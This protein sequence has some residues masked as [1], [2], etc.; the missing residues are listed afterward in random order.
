MGGAVGLGL[1]ER[2]RDAAAREDWQQAFELFM[3]AETDGLLAPAELALLGEV[4][5]AA[6]HLDVAIEAW[7][8]AHAGYLQAGNPDRGRGCGR[9]R[10]DAPPL[11]HCPEGTSAWLGCDTSG[12][13][14][15]RHARSI[16][17]ELTMSG[18]HGLSQAR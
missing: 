5:Y 4:A 10:R 12:A 16:G 7:E 2:A 8:R 13:A 1:V 11:R 17:K 3:E 9:S 6:G 14:S 15:G 18:S